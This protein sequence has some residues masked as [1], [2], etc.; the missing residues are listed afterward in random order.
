MQAAIVICTRNRP[1]LLARCLAAV[2]QLDPTPYQVIVVDNSQGNPETMKLTREFGA[3]Y[4]LEPRFGLN[5]ARERGLA[6]CRA[7][8]V[9][10]LADYEVPEPKW[11][12][13]LEETLQ[14]EGTGITNVAFHGCKHLMDPS[15]CENSEG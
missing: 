7:K 14:T 11:L 9:A 10:F 1:A 2:G 12:E 5:C 3:Q 4:V 6:E 8:A 13:T 15:T